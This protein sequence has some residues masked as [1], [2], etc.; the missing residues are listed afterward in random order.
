MEQVE[1]EKKKL[2]NDQKTKAQ[3]MINIFEQVQDA[4]QHLASFTEGEWEPFDSIIDSGA[5]VPVMPLEMGKAY[6]ATDGAAKKAGVKYK[7]ADGTDLPNLGEKVMAVWTQ[8]GTVR[9]YRSQCADVTKPLQAVRALVASDHSVVF[10]KGGSF[11]FNKV[12]GEINTIT[13]DGINYL[14]RQWVIPPDQIEA[15]IHMAQDFQGP[16]NQ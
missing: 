9:A 4:A 13:D 5:T 6:P 3:Q 14:M 16:A 1:T 7:I 12:S 15:A 11:V 10:D 8:E 2:I